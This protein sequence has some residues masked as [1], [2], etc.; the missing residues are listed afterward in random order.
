MIAGKHDLS[1]A[2]QHLMLEQVT[3]LILTLNEA[4][5]IQRTLE[6]LAWASDIVVVD[7]GSTD[8]TRE[9][10][11][12]HDRVRVFERPF[13]THA[14]QWNYGLE[15]T[16]IRTDWVLALDADF[17]LTDALVRELTSLEPAPDVDGY[18]ASFVYCMEGVPL[19]GAV[20]PPVVALYRRLGARYVQDGHTQRVELAG[21]VESLAAKILHDDR[22]PLARWYSAQLGYMQMEARKLHASPFWSLR[23]PDRVRKLVI[24]APVAML[25]YCLIVKG[26]LLDGRRGLLYALQ[27]ATAE[28]ILSLLLLEAKLRS[29]SAHEG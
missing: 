6:K 20:Y 3:P 18:R 27:R 16:A 23:W 1:R 15:R 5:N 10:L 9:V 13:T 7:S 17:V 26:N 2:R 4:P 28:A 11:A 19:R 14:E 25:F 22:K 29:E 12:R 21:R 8:A 24:V